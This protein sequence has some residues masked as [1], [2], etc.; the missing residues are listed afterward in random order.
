VGVAPFKFVAKI[1]SDHRKPDGLTVIPPDRVLEF[2]HPLPVGVLWGVGP[3]TLERLKGIGIATV[4]DLAAMPE[5]R[6]RLQL[7]SRGTQL[8]RMAHG[9]DPRPV[10]PER[11]RRSRSAERTFEEDVHDI[12]HLVAV[13]ED[14]AARIASGV[15]EAGDK[16][17]TVTL[18]LRYADFSTVTRALTLPEGIDDAAS[19]VQAARELLERTEAGERPVRLIGVGLSKFASETLAPGRQLRLPLE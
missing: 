4:G 11:V 13:I 8:W 18:K 6:L 3:S 19:L 10:K 12:E 17:R 9:D 15:R 1:A 2:V 16:G 5:E 14:Q 7:G